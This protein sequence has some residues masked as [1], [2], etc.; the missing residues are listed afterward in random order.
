M[1]DGPYSCL[2]AELLSINVALHPAVLIAINRS[3]ATVDEC[4]FETVA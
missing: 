4:T 3:Q 1:E 2:P